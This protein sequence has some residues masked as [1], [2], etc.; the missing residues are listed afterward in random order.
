MGVGLKLSRL[1]LSRICW[2]PRVALA[3]T[4]ALFVGAGLAHAAHLHKSDSAQG[5]NHA[6]HCGLCIQL[7]RVASPPP[8]PQFDAVD[9]NFLRIPIARLVIPAAFFLTHPYEARGPPAAG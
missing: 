6:V 9:R 7:E 1:R 2:M 5:G 3:V 8:A 4:L